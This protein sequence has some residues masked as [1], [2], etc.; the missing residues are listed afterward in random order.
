MIQLPPELWSI[1]FHHKRKQYLISKRKRKRYFNKLCRY[2]EVN[3]EMYIMKYEEGYIWYNTLR[4]KTL[5]YEKRYEE[6]NECRYCIYTRFDKE[7]NFKYCSRNL[8][9]VFFY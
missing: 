8:N 5:H 9:S 2:L 7:T 3:L 1:I 6:D 4:S